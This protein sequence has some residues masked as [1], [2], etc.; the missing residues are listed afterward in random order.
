MLMIHFL[1]IC[2]YI[3]V[4]TYAS[5][6][7]NVSKIDIWLF[8]S[9]WCK[10]CLWFLC[11]LTICRR[12]R[13]WN[14]YAFNMQPPF[15]C[16]YH[17]S[18]YLSWMLPL[19]RLHWIDLN[20]GDCWVEVSNWSLQQKTPKSVILSC[21]NPRYESMRRIK[22]DNFVVYIMWICFCFI[23]CRKFEKEFNAELQS[24]VPILSNSSQAE[25]YLTHLAQCILGVGSEQWVTRWFLHHFGTGKVTLFLTC[26]CE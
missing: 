3:Q 11:Y 26:N 8:R 13:S 17:Q 1:S 16:W 2:L 5:S 25:P 9:F 18:I 14:Q 21:M 7:N 23:W 20:Q 19:A 4:Y 6:S 22:M 10:T 24:L 15:N 12:S